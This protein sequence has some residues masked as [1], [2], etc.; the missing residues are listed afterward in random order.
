MDIK[1][2]HEYAES[3]FSK[4]SSLMLLWQEQAE[5]FYV[6]RADFTV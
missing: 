5:N 3:L 1:Q 4:R 2:L 6:Q